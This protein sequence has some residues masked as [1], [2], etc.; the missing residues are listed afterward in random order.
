MN[1]QKNAWTIMYTSECTNNQPSA[2]AN[3]SMNDWT[4]KWLNKCM[5]EW[6]N[7]WLHEHMHPWM[8]DE[9]AIPGTTVQTHEWMTKC[10]NTWMENQPNDHMN[11]RRAWTTKCMTSDWTNFRLPSQHHGTKE[12]ALVLQSLQPSQSLWSDGPDWPATP[13]MPWSDNKEKKD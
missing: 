6:M 11:I 1:K 8:N 13:T 10:K 3:I 12:G 5:N 9:W 7:N 2:N 4:T